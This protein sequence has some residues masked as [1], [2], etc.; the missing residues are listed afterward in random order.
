[1]NGVTGIGIDNC[2]SIQWR[3]DSAK[4]GLAD[5]ERLYSQ[6]MSTGKYGNANLVAGQISQWQQRI[7]DL[8]ADARR[9]NCNL[10]QSFFLQYLFIDA[11]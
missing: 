1:M 8:E 5:A 2:A 7:R 6:M 3:Y 9:G 11:P 10:H 4:K